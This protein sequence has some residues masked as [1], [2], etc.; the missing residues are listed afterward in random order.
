MMP[1]TAPLTPKPRIDVFISSTSIDLPEHR[2]AVRDAIL[3]LGLF[4]S[5]ME[6]WPK[7][8]ESPVDKCRRMVAD[9]ELYVGIF[10]YRYGWRPDGAGQPSITE[11]EYD[12]AA[13]PRADGTSRPRLCFVMAD[14]HPWPEDQKEREA[15]DDLERFKAR[16][17]QREVGFFTT[18]D[19][20]KA[21]VVT[22]LSP[23]AQLTRD[24]ALVPYLRWLHEQSKRSG[25]LHVLTPSDASA[26]AKP[27]TVEQVYTPLD[28]RSMIY[29]DERGNIIPPAMAEAR[30]QGG[31][32]DKVK[33]V[34]VTAMEA[35]TQHAHLVLLG[36]PGSGKSTFLNFLALCLS[37]QR[38][39]PNGGWLERLS[40]QGWTHGELVPLVVTLR[41]FAQDVPPSA[42]EGMAKLLF[43]HLERQ[44]AKW[45]LED[46]LPAIH[47]ALNAGRALVMLD[48]LDE[49]P[50]ERRDLV[51]QTVQDFIARCHPTNRYLVTCRILSYT[52][53]AWKL[54]GM[55][56]ETIAPFT[57]PKIEHFV[58]AWYTA[59]QALGGID[60]DL[61]KQRVKDLIG[62]LRELQHLAEN[63]MLLTVMAIVHNHTGALPRESARLYAECVDLLL[64]RWKPHAA[65]SLLET[66][67]VRE[68]DLFRLLWEIAFDAHD[69]QAERAGA[70]D[71]PET[72]I[73]GIARNRFGGDSA[74]AN[75]FV[76]YIEG[77]AGLLIGRG[78]DK[79]GWRV[80]TFPHRTFQ[81]YLAGCH[82]ASDRLDQNIV[83]Y[84]RRGAAWREA[85]MLAT[86]HLVFN[87]KRLSDP[88]YAVQALMGE[89]ETP[90]TDADWR[91]VW[92][93]G[94]MLK[95]IELPS[96]EGHK[97]GQRVLP[98]VRQRLA[99]LV[100]GGHLPVTERASAGRILSVLGDPR[101]GVGCN[102]T[103]KL[104]DIAWCEV[105]AG[106]FIYQDGEK[107]TLER[108]FIAK[109]P[110][111]YMQ[112]QAFLDADDG[113][114]NPEW[115]KD[116]HEE[117]QAQQW[118]G[119]GDQR[120]KH[121]N[122][123]RE[124]IS[125]YDSMA[126]CA[127]LNHQVREGRLTLPDYIPAGFEIRL[128]T[129]AEWEKAARGT[130]GRKYPYE[131]PFDAN[132]G[133]T[134]ETG[135]NM[136]SAVGMFPAG[137]SPYGALDMSGNV[138]EWTRTEYDAEINNDISNNK[139][140][141]LRG[142]SWS[143]AED[144]ARAATRNRN[145]PF[146]RNGLL[147]G[148]VA[149]AAPIK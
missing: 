122:H 58:R 149:S 142:G 94:D 129:E 6:T 4:P 81:E 79:Y 86:G 43:D 7:S 53:S 26:D 80:F 17:R 12:W 146:N 72:E 88:L 54:A 145:D 103:T 120:F 116:L 144:S 22:A 3:S 20:L 137:A 85:L 30:R 128:P 126:F 50:S 114:R 106:E 67:N 138:W 96:V 98:L 35:A 76:E 104:P 118:E 11:M 92:L 28:T 15:H 77:R 68:D 39:D 33:A 123:P 62:A 34:P 16:V 111:T 31:K 71:I 141:V 127:W 9:A 74:K 25:L 52:N 55:A 110:I 44:L 121:W 40:K 101:P 24:Q 69:K 83:D 124:N 73:V 133:N 119:A 134:R 140:R 75:A 45:K 115:W 37:G 70:A 29:R 59:M 27:I 2:A 97:I 41:D 42:S 117:G 13:E 56:E 18:P 66:L 136:T 139:P 47:A 78:T 51:R 87:D 131:G 8:G 112:F 46:A 38:I 107:R 108:F 132:K 113:Y 23:Y 14:S 1:N 63:P 89:T 93:A 130:D 48:G 60:P 21:Q 57:R 125:W 100:G 95:L 147:G 135:L 65:R 143:S 19:D 49:V 102:P 64:L 32:D 10:A 91:M 5:G 82:L 61:A 90:H 84:A 99:A 109:Y 148:R 36:D 105:P